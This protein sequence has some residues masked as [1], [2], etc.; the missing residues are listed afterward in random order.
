MILT[1]VL[2]ALLAAGPETDGGPRVAASSKPTAAEVQA[3]PPRRGGNGS[4]D[5]WT[6]V[7]R[8]GWL[9]RSFELRHYSHARFWGPE[10]VHAAVSR[11]DSDP[12]KAI[13]AYHE[14]LKSVGVTLLV[15]PI[16]GKLMLYG[17]E[18]DPPLDTSPLEETRRQYLQVLRDRGVQV[19][20]FLPEM[21]KVR[22]SGHVAY[23]PRDSHWSA[24]SVRHAAAVLAKRIRAESWYRAPQPMPKAT[25]KPLLVQGYPDLAAW[26]DVF[27]RDKV[28]PE[29]EIRVL[30]V[31]VN[32]QFTQIDR[33]SPV[34]L[35]GD[36]SNLVFNSILVS[37]H[38]GL[39]D[40]LTAELGFPV[41]SVGLAGE[42]AV[43]QSLAALAR[44]H[45]NLA[46][47][48]VVIL[49]FGERS[50]T[51]QPHGWPII[52]IVRPAATP[53]TPAP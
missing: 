3:A 10:A 1:S 47:K 48:K 35:V 14:M 22:D 18:L 43:A 17:N 44:R 25:V 28:P 13:V 31:K 19:I 33:Q 39:S 5:T 16:P 6:S 27:Q 51:G 24:E 36:S 52:P 42:E 21:Q 23:L 46:G 38:G 9:F 7:G 2:L 50:L 11:K 45:A 34:V 30:Q 29:E 4:D 49:C 53:A 20:D 12:L 37:Q 26:Q 15:L 41:D 32:D 8:E 40:H